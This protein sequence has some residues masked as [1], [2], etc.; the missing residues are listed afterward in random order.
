M[1]YINFP[2]PL[3][4]AAHDCKRLAQALLS[5]GRKTNLYPGF[6]YVQQILPFPSNCAEDDFQSKS[7]FL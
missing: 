2:W 4:V 3:V 5:S 7:H 1:K 6:Y